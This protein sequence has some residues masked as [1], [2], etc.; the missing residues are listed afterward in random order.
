MS[1]RTAKILSALPYFVAVAEELHFARAAKRLGMSQ[2]PLS[3][4][5]QILEKELGA[6]LFQRTKHHVSLTGAGDLLFKRARDLISLG[7]EAVEEIHKLTIGSGLRVRVGFINSSLH[8]ILPTII[9]EFSHLHADVELELHEV[10]TEAQITRLK[11]GTLDIGLLR[12][13]QGE[14][15]G[16][17]TAVIWR[18]PLVVVLPVGHHLANRRCVHLQELRHDRFVTYSRQAVP[19]LRE[20]IVRGCES[21]GFSPVVVQ[22]ARRAATLISLVAAGFGIGLVPATAA[23]TAVGQVKFVHLDGIGIDVEVSVAISRAN[24]SEFVEAFFTLASRAASAHA[25]RAHERDL[26]G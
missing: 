15:H 3:R 20:R 8:S 9:T 13:V 18:D 22:E 11:L 14:D 25:A 17:R 23:E 19:R 1:T 12:L 26:L 10:S 16:L 5:I 7:E 4:R 6:K 24:T 21:V 2:P